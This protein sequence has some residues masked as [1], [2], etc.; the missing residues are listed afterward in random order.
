MT[1]G[2]AKNAITPEKALERLQRLCA[3]QEKCTHDLVLKLRQWGLAQT[4]IDLVI[5]RLISDGYV[6]DSRYATLY[7]REKSRLNGWGPIKLRAM[8]TAKGIAKN[9][10]NHALDK[11]NDAD[12]NARLADLLRKKMLQVKARSRVDLRNKLIRFGLSRGFPLSLV[13]EAVNN[14]LGPDEYD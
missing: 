8:L 2:D 7:V 14:L 6:D 10:I 11:L 4:D 13:A 5:G 9:I 3:Q 1:K 12:S